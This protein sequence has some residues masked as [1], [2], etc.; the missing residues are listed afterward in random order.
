M[1]RIQKEAWFFTNP[2]D[3]LAGAPSDKCRTNNECIILDYNTILDKKEVN[4][5]RWIY[6]Q[7]VNQTKKEDIEQALNALPYDIPYELREKSYK[8]LLGFE[9]KDEF[10]KIKDKMSFDESDALAKTAK[11]MKRYELLLPAY[12]LHRDNHSIHHK[13]DKSELSIAGNDIIAALQNFGFNIRLEDNCYG[14]GGD[15]FYEGHSIKY[16][17]NPIQQKS[18][19]G[20]NDVEIFRGDKVLWA[21]SSTY[22]AEGEVIDIFPDKIRIKAKD[23]GY[24]SNISLD[25]FTFVKL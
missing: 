15:I 16:Q 22:F 8:Y 6:F 19:K 11:K 2:R 9:D 18:F 25:D 14:D 12:T 1:Y 3:Y 17:I 10:D 21:Y 5:N 13:V 23:N 24:E 7:R 4:W 20:Y